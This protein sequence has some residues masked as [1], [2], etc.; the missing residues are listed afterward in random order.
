MDSY[1]ATVAHIN[2]MAG[3]YSAYNFL[4]VRGRALGVPASQRPFIHAFFW[5][6]AQGTSLSMPEAP[7]MNYSQSRVN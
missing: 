2:K 4:Q 1:T 5:M 3:I 7:F 6:A